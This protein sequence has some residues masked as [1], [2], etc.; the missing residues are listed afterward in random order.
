MLMTNTS[1]DSIKSYT[2]K[3]KRHSFCF[4]HAENLELKISRPTGLSTRREAKH[5]LFTICIDAPP[6]SSSATRIASSRIRE[7]VRER[8]R[9]KK[10]KEDKKQEETVRESLVIDLLAGVN[11]SR[12]HITRRLVRDSSYIYHSP[13][14]RS[15]LMHLFGSDL[16]DEA[17]RQ[18]RR[19][20]D[21]RPL[22]SS[23]IVRPDSGSKKRRKRSS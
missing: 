17:P 7:K 6:R 15:P 5:F 20:I 1:I 4:Y 22:S 10:R 9:E 12:L 3:M 18:C 14:I 19:K 8:E 16:I 23:G 21:D 13:S 11:F 2:Q